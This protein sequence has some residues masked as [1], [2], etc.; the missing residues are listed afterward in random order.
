MCSVEPEQVFGVHDVSS[1]YHVPILLE[2]QNFLYAIS[3]YLDIPSSLPRTPTQRIADGSHMWKDWVDL[4]QSQEAI[5][6][7]L[8][9]PIALVGKYVSHKD[10]YLSISKSLEHA[11]MYCH[12]RV[13]IIWINASDLDPESYI[14]S[15]AKYHKA[16]HDLCSAR[17]V[18]VPGGFGVRATT[19]MIKAI[20]WARINNKPFLG[21]CLGMQLAIIEYSQSIGIEDP[22]S[23]ELHPLAKNNVIVYMPETDKDKLGGTM[24]LGKHPCIFQKDTEWSKVR[25]LYGP[26]SRIEERHRHRYEVNPDMVDRLEE[27]GLSF[28]AKDETGKRMEIVE[29]RNHPWFVGVQFHPEYLSRVLRPSKVFLGFFAAATGT[30]CLEKVTEALEQGCRSLERIDSI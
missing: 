25:A 23:E 29:L 19:G 1:T 3:K 20:N 30:R 24:R 9:I 10:A 6:D 7:T 26:V 2:R 14:D 27:A 28:V 5:Q 21:V 18:L 22:G 13:E 4:I 11:A 12:K 8:S 17:G 15:P 16:W